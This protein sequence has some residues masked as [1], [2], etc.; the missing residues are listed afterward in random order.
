MAVDKPGQ[1]WPLVLAWE[2]NKV[3]VS[4]MCLDIVAGGAASLAVCDGKP[5]QQ[6]TL[7]PVGHPAGKAQLVSGAGGCLS[8]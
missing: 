2:A 6:W 7:K 1:A 4:H 8:T 5:S 3:G